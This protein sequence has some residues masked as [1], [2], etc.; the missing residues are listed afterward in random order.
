MRF[1]TAGGTIQAKMSSMLPHH[2]SATI[3]SRLAR[4]DRPD[5][6][7]MLVDGDRW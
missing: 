5:F 3:G 4:F 1:L 7:G 2:V 6:C